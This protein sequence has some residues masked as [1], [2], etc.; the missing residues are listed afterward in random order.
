MKENGVKEC[1]K[2]YPLWRNI[3]VYGNMEWK[4]ND[5]RFCSF[6]DPVVDQWN[7]KEYKNIKEAS[8]LTGISEKEIKDNFGYDERWGYISKYT[9]FL[10][11]YPISVDGRIFK[12]ISEVSKIM[13]IDEDDIRRCIN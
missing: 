2:K 3:D 11:T 4:Y 5:K 7:K 8:K 6:D 12:N 13:N 1:L 9:Q 10:N